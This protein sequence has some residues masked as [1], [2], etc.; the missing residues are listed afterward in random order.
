MTPECFPPCKCGGHA[1]L[2]SGCGHGL[3]LVVAECDQ[4]HQRVRVVAPADN[5]A[6]LSLADF[7]RDRWTEEMSQ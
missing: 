6:A 2:L 4:C 3:L 7:L 5:P 1:K